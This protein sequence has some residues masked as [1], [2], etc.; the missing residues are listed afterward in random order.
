MYKY[1]RVDRERKRLQSYG[2]RSRHDNN[3]VFIFCVFI[4]NNRTKCQTTETNI[5][6]T[7]SLD[8]SFFDY[9]KIL[10]V[11]KSD[12]KD[13]LRTFSWSENVELK[14]KDCELVKKKTWFKPKVYNSLYRILFTNDWERY[15]QINI[16]NYLNSKRKSTCLFKLN[17]VADEGV[18]GNKKCTHEILQL[19]LVNL[20]N[21]TCF[22]IWKSVQIYISSVLNKI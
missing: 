11:L 22:M 7:V 14:K 13:S 1:S 20:K 9:L 6:G 5:A 16:K 3:S 8:F 2:G 17:F 18:Q 10:L 15:F 12:N 21:S 4:Y 19:F